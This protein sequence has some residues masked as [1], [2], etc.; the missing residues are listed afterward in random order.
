MPSVNI[1]AFILAALLIAM[2]GLIFRYVK[3]KLSASEEY[4]AVKAFNSLANGNDSIAFNELKKIALSGN[5]SIE[6]YSALSVLYRKN[7]EILKA[8][9]IN[10]SILLRDKVSVDTSEEIFNELIKCYQLKPDASIIKKFVSK[11]SEDIK[12]DKILILNAIAEKAEGNFNEAVKLLRKYEK[13]TK[14]DQS[15]YI[16]NI[17]Y[18]H[19]LNTDDISKKIKLLKQAADINPENRMALFALAS[20]YVNADKKDAALSVYRDIIKNNLIRSK[21]D[22]ELI[23]NIF[24]SND[25][26]NELY[27]LME[28]KVLAGDSFPAAY[29]FVYSYQKKRGNYEQAE[30]ILSDYLSS[31]KSAIIL[32]E[33][34][35]SKQD[36]MLSNFVPIDAIYICNV[37]GAKYS[38]FKDTCSE[39][40]SVDSLRFN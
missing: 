14:E 3:N 33:Y 21:D 35:R 37:C 16:S 36:A 34:I 13:N 40:S 31:N 15:E 9:H 1:T 5:A 25:K 24:Y 12:S 19:A 7:Q 17:Y 29:L 32:K 10:E 22:L 6:M 30:T 18:V 2:A 23:E 8:I 27:K 26:L 28:E 20:S 39:C 38:Y 11:L 4:C